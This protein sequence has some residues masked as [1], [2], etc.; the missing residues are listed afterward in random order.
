MVKIYIERL[1]AFPFSLIFA[2]HGSVNSMLKIIDFLTSPY[3]YS[4]KVD[5]K[6]K[7]LRNEEETDMAR[8]KIYRAKRTVPISKEQLTFLKQTA[9]SIFNQKRN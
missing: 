7:G 9:R 5:M 3:L 2:A 4:S 1:G 8:W 6:S